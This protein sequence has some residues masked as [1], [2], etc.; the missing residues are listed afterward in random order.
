MGQITKCLIVLM[1]LLAV[2]FQKSK[3]T[4]VFYVLSDHSVNVSCSSQPCHSHTLGQYLLINN[5]I[6]PQVTNVEYH[7]FPG[8]HQVPANMVLTNLCNFSIIGDISEPSSPAVLVGCDDWYVLKITASYNVSIRNVRFERCYNRQ[9]QVQLTQYFTSLYISQ[10]FSCGIDNV[11]FMNF[12]IIGHNLIGQSYLNEIYVTHTTGQFF[13][14]IFLSCTDS[15]QP[16]ANENHILINKLY[17]NVIG[18]GRKCYSFNEY[19]TAGVMVYITVHAEKAI[20]TIS[21]SSFSRLHSTAMYIRSKCEA[22]QNIISLDNCI[23]DSMLTINEPVVYV[24]LLENNNFI[25]LNNCTFKHNFA[26]DNILV[27]IAIKVVPDVTC[28]FSY[29]KQNLVTPSN[30][31]F[32]KNQFIS[33]FGKILCIDSV[34]SKRTLHIIGPFSITGNDACTHHHSDL[35]FIN[36]M[37]VCIHGPLIISHNTA[38]INSIW[39]F[40]LSEVTFHGTILFKYNFCY[41]V[42]SLKTTLYIKVMEYANITFVGNRCKNTIIGVEIGDSWYNYCLFQYIKSSN[43]SIVMPNNYAINIIKTLRTQ[44]EGC[45][46]LYYRL[47][48]KCEWLPNVTFQHYDSE[49]VN[50]Q[51]IQTDQQHL[52]YHRICI[53]NDNESY[54]CSRNMLGPIYP[55]QVLQIGLCTP[56]DDNTIF[57]LYAE[58][59][60][61]LEENF[62]C[63]ISNQAEILNSIS[64]RVKLINYTI[65][66]EAHKVCK[67]F[68]TMYSHKKLYAYEIFM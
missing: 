2:E 30:V 9:L 10:C 60:D 24:D 64:S 54:N 46:F 48:P 5:G 40:V 47:N 67:L 66:S 25:S 55:G 44:N 37:I 14:G 59:R 68:L 65:A 58:T 21:N 50:H 35:I 28:D 7:F 36:N 4:D 34:K 18:T 32:R 42:I 63:R 17:I 56:C 39:K 26:Q 16:Q 12:G 27:S 49:V 62:S 1:F 52:N 23:F 22:S 33:N 15:N 57:D 45:S 13:Q 51:I 41:Q 43:K 31:H 19:S 6:L 3:A 38:K 53:C 61:S 11:T 8:E 20:I 29:N